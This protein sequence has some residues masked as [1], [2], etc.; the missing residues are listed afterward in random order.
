[1]KD[2]AASV[3]TRLLNL[4]R[5]DGTPFQRLL[6]LY[7]QEGLLHR[8]V[9]TRYE[10]SVVLKG[11][12]LFYQ[13]QGMAARPTKDIDLMDKRRGG[14]EAAL[15]TILDSAS[16]VDVDDGLRFDRDS[17]EV[18]PIAGQTEH[19]GVR[20]GITGY[21]G[22]ART[23]LQIDMGFGDV[24]TGGPVRRYYRTILGNRSFSI[25]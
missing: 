23:H 10:N 18:K 3:R 20:G 12:L 9:S 8:I 15:R 22:T 5:K 16:I 25:Q 21:L 7:N 24:I 1:M 2:M 14:S 6:T 4:A 11:G 19:G 17:V 13:L